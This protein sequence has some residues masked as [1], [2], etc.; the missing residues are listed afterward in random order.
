MTD[1]KRSD[2]AGDGDL[3]R[4]AEHLGRALLA[5]GCT[6]ATA[7]SCTGGLVGAWITSI[8]GSSEWYQG[9]FV[10]YANRAK[11]AL[12]GVEAGVLAQYGAVSDIVARRMASGARRRLGSDLAVAVT[13]IA[14]PGGG[15]PA[16]PV[17]LVYIAVDTAFG[18]RCTRHAFEGDREGVRRSAA[19]AALAAL[20]AVLEEEGA[21]R[22]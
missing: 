18:S 17:G 19:H 3:R 13:G 1:A 20:V 4:I 11:T 9:G 15:S 6:V 2:P 16:K 7:E 12:L 14:G 10:T 21:G 5:A 22:P 8:P